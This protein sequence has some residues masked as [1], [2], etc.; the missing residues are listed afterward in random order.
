MVCRDLN[1]DV[2]NSSNGSLNHGNSILP[3]GVLLLKN[4]RNRKTKNSDSTKGVFYQF[5]SIVIVRHNCISDH[6]GVETEE[7]FLTTEKILLKKQ[8]LEF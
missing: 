4:E 2:S 3:F 1:G 6:E 8:N 7:T 5:C